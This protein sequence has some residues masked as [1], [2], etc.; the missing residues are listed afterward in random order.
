[1]KAEY[2]MVS[3]I[4]IMIVGYCLFVGGGTHIAAPPVSSSGVTKASIQVPTDING[5][6]VE[7]DNIASRLL[8]DNSV[9]SIKFLYV[10][11][12][13]SGQVLLTST[14]KGKVTSSGKR[15]TPYT[16]ASGGGPDNAYGIPIDLG[17]QTYD[18]SEV[19]QDDG[20][21]GESSP[22]IYWWNTNGQYFQYFLSSNAMVMLSDQPMSFPHVLLN[23]DTNQ[24]T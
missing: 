11:S 22:Y 4:A 18:T 23:V 16:V 5:N 8:M 12:P 3:I 7:Q 21:Y 6:T 24:S 9:G 1:M 15:L 14:V 17:G 20:T 13:Y 10:I 19:L 2:I